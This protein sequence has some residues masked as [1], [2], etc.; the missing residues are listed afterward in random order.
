M[1]LYR[2]K[3]GTFD[4]INGIKKF[5]FPTMNKNKIQIKKYGDQKDDFCI[6]FN[7]FGNGNRIFISHDQSASLYSPLWFNS[8]IEPEHQNIFSSSQNLPSFICAS[9]LSANPEEVKTIFVWFEQSEQDEGLKYIADFKANYQNW[10]AN[11]NSF[12]LDDLKNDYFIPH[13]Q[14]IQI[15]DNSLELLLSPTDVNGASNYK[16][17]LTSQFIY[18]N[19][20]TSAD[21]FDID[22]AFR[23]FAGNWTKNG[24]DVFI[25]FR[26]F[27][28][29]PKQ[30][31]IAVKFSIKIIDKRLMFF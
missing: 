25:E 11:L 7:Y 22:L 26:P 18:L 19:Q 6:S 3:D 12:N 4:S 21:T 15:D 28:E 20:L 9:H 17:Q 23:S 16:I 29:D 27:S 2:T 5:Y 10:K 8:K 31:S 1:D 14:N 24:G 30:I 13:E